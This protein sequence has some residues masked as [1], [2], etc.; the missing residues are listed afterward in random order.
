MKV[1]IAGIANDSIVDGPGLRLTVFFQG[2][3]HNCYMCHNPQTHDLNGGREEDTENILKKLDDNILLSGITISGGEPFLQPEAAKELA[4]GTKERG[5]N[6]IIYTG[7]TYEELIKNESCTSVL[8][9]TDILIDGKFEYNKRSL[10]LKFRGSSNQRAID[11]RKTMEENE[12]R[13]VD[14]DA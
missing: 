8:K 1:R 5:M 11:V 7:F 12:I 13:E 3:K 14:F 6:V 4:K 10:E 9:Y 2:C